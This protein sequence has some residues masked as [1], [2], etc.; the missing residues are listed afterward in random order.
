MKAY[1]IHTVFHFGKHLNK[2]VLTVCKVDPS[3]I[4]WCMINLE[5]FFIS[6]DTLKD[7]ISEESSFRLSN[8]A[9]L[10]QEGKQIE[11]ES[12]FEEPVENYDYHDPYEDYGRSGEEYGWY[13][14]WSDDVINDAF[15]G[16]PEATWNV[17]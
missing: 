14:G 1:T 12:Q 7:I 9:N 5:H 13:N 8:E 6:D 16:D 11:W 17:D 15:D 10:V 4:S 3:Y 2:S